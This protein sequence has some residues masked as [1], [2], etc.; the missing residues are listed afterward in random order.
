MI[1]PTALE[2]DGWDTGLMV[3]GTGEGV[4]TCRRESGSLPDQ[5]NR[6]RFQ[7][8]EMTP[9]FKAFLVK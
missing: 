3:L 8:R 7:R 6:R 2:A 1:A 4:E 5:Q 9:Q